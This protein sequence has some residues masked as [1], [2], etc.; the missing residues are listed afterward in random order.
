M[1]VSEPDDGALAGDLIT[2]FADIHGEG[3]GSFGFVPPWRRFAIAGPAAASAIALLLFCSR[4]IRP[5]LPTPRTTSAVEVHL[6]QPAPPKPAGLQGGAALAP[7]A[8]PKRIARKPPVVHHKIVE[9]PHPPPQVTTSA[10]GSIAIPAPPATAAKAEPGT[11][12]GALGSTGVGSGSG[13]GTDSAG[14]RAIYAP[15][16]I[17]P[18]DMRESDFQSVAVAQFKVLA[19][20]DVIV[21]LIKPTP[22]PR[23]NEIVLSTLKRWKFFP[24]LRDGIAVD[25]EFEVRIPISVQ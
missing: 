12:V 22:N 10:V 17:I 6:I 23:L 16:P 25:S 14:A 21:M 3:Q 20:G 24:A 9:A 19:D 11:G 1:G 18:D 7:H 13:L 4:F 2:Q 5:E 8:K 15:L